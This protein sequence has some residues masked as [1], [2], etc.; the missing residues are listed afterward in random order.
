LRFEKESQNVLDDVCDA[1]L[2][3]KIVMKTL[4]LQKKS[5]SGDGEINDSFTKTIRQ[6]GWFHFCE[7][8]PNRTMSTSALGGR[9]NSSN[10]CDGLILRFEKEASN[11]DKCMGRSQNGPKT[12][13]A[14]ILRFEIESQ[15]QRNWFLRFKTESQM[16]LNALRVRHFDRTLRMHAFGDENTICKM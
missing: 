16:M 1:K 12:T 2:N 14:L 8:Q 4:V 5:Q 15:I 6:M 3:R 9:K 13:D 7:S 10:T 11:G